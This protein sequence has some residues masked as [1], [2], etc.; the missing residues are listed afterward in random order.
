MD[1]EKTLA[2][3]L[4]DLAAFACLRTGDESSRR[5]FEAAC[6]LVEKDFPFDAQVYRAHVSRPEHRVR[7]GNG[8]RGQR[9]SWPPRGHST[10]AMSA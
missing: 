6:S 4:L 5:D 7:D 3:L 10:P 9:R 2:L 1:K 8:W